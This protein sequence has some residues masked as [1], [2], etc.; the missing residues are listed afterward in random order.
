[1]RLC[2]SDT[3][4]S[5]R[6]VA[7][8]PWWSMIH[9]WLLDATL[10]RSTMVP[11][12]LALSQVWLC[13]SAVDVTTWMCTVTLF[14]CQQAGGS[15]GGGNDGGGSAGSGEDGGG[16][17]GGG[18]GGGGEGGGGDGG[19]GD[20]G[21]EDGGGDGGGEGGGGDGGGGEGGGG[22][23]GGDGSCGTHVMF[24]WAVSTLSKRTLVPSALALR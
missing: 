18:D 19:G 2:E 9:C 10:H 23:G 1:M 15:A 8:A 21:G 16:D 4:V 7:Y 3:D 6:I 17:D 13:D 14:C 11:S 12:S 5:T 20:A 24:H 22:D